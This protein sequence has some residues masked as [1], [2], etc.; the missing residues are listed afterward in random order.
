MEAAFT[1]FRTGIAIV[2]TIVMG[3]AMIQAIAPAPGEPARMPIA[4]PPVC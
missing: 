3:A 4:C 1:R 2:A